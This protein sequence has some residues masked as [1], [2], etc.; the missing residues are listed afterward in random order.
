M[1]QNTYNE[2]RLRKIIDQ[3]RKIMDQSD[4]STSSNE[5]S[6]EDLDQT[7]KVENEKIINTFIRGYIGIEKDN[8]FENILGKYHESEIKNNK[9]INNLVITV[10]I[11]GLF[12]FAIG[13]VGR[14]AGFLED[15][16]ITTI[17]GALSEIIGVVIKG[18]QVQSDKNKFVYFKTLDRNNERKIIS[19]FI[20]SMPEGKAKNRMI[21][22]MIDGYFSDSDSSKC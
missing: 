7:I 10:I 19:Y 12:F 8:S 18:F 9:H 2:E 3:Y 4:N 13:L 14:V 21:E 20:K 16:T 1:P 11:I 6:A 17:G 22:K 15:Q 5:H